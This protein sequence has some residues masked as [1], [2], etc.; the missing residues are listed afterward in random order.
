MLAAG[1]NG[2]QM[3]T[4]DLDEA[5]LWLGRRIAADPRFPFA[6][7]KIAYQG[8][9]GRKPVDYPEDFDAPDYAPRFAAWRDQE[10][11]FQAIGAE[12][13]ASNFNLKVVFRELLMSPFYRGL[14]VDSEP[15]EWRALELSEIGTERLSTPMLLARKI[16]AITGLP[17]S[18][19]WDRSDNLMTD[20]RILYGGIDS[21]TI[22]ERLTVPNG[23]IASVAWRMANEMACSATAWDFYQP[24][25]ERLLFP[26]V[27]A[28]DSPETEAGDTVQAAVDRIKQ[29][30]VHLHSH[31]LG[32]TLA[33]DDP[34]V[35]RTYQ[36]FLQTWRAGKGLMADDTNDIGNGLPWNCRVRSSRLTGEE[37]PEGERLEQ[38]PN[39][40][41]RSWMAVMTYL[42]SDYAFL[43]E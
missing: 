8:L 32:E 42:L 25:S 28:E 15:E 9:M 22:T 21:D 40:A 11:L 13:A 3:P 34:E 6:I 5:P 31:V 33:I 24:A 10:S 17:W 27:T 4:S 41:I 23:V 12:F 43:Y 18:R 26:L 20:Y 29:N 7:V 1:F 30:I 35:E 38:D 36:L 14:G 19:G 39:Y 37:L 16:E 2:E